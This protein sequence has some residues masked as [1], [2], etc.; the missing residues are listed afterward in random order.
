AN[1]NKRSV[2]VD[3]KTTE[4]RALVRRLAALVDVVVE[5]NR[6]HVAA[7]WGLD[8][9][10]LVEVRPDLVYLSSQGYG[11]SGPYAD[12]QAYGANVSAASAVTYLWNHPDQPVPVGTSLNH[13]DH[14]ASKQGAVAVLAA[15]DYRRRTGR[16]GHLDLS[17]QEVAIGLIG[18]TVLEAAATGRDPTPIGN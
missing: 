12:Y 1:R 4:G 6:G 11:G 3:L 7:G 9:R 16:G 18:E 5:N 10:A 17:Q 13:P 2:V 14:L 15:L 8:Y